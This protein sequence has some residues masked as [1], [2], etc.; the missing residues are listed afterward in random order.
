MQQK[1]AKQVG[2]VFPTK[3]AFSVQIAFSFRSAQGYLIL[4]SWSALVAIY[5]AFGGWATT[6]DRS[7]VVRCPRTGKAALAKEGGCPNNRNPFCRQI[8]SEQ[9]SRLLLLSE[10]DQRFFLPSSL[11]LFGRIGPNA[12][13]RGQSHCVCDGDP[14]A[15]R[16][17]VP[18][19]DT[20]CR[21]ISPNTVP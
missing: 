9:C 15:R 20:M 19:L 2:L 7:I 13:Q 10:G 4:I 16:H 8:Q 1:P 6:W 21:A 18:G 17:W 11:R 3:C 12:V 14:F 5:C